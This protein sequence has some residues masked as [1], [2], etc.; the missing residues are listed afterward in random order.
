MWTLLVAMTM[1]MYTYGAFDNKADC[2]EAAETLRKLT[3][4]AVCIQV[5]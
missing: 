1:Q 5:K 3:V 4:K 2:L